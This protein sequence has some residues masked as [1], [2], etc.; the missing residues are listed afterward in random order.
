MPLQAS[1]SW[2]V[3]VCCCEAHTSCWCVVRVPEQV[4]CR[5]ADCCR[6]RWSVQTRWQKN[7]PP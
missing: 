2:A 5:G 1:D 3:S 4:G 7:A 6:P